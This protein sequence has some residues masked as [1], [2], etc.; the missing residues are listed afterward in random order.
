V[1]SA[2][3]MTILVVSV[4]VQAWSGLEESDSEPGPKVRCA[5][6]RAGIG[7]RVRR[8]PVRPLNRTPAYRARSPSQ[9]LCLHLFMSY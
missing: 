9:V 3:T 4:Q 6:P 8:L 7:Y 2:L 1:N 5:G